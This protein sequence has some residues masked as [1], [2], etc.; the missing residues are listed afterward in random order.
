MYCPVTVQ[1]RRRVERIS[2]AAEA[3]KFLEAKHIPCFQDLFASRRKIPQVSCWPSSAE[4]ERA[5]EPLEIA[6]SSGNKTREERAGKRKGK[7][8]TRTG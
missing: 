7:R 8:R 6:T 1:K 4:V 3:F 2:F 5:C